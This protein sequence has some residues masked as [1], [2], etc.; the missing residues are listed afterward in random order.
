MSHLCRFNTKQVL[1][2]FYCAKIC[3]INFW[4]LHF[5]YLISCWYS[6]LQSIIIQLIL[7][8]LCLI[9]FIL[10][11][12]N[13]TDIIFFKICKFA[14]LLLSQEMESFVCECDSE[15]D[16]LIIKWKLIVPRLFFSS[17]FYIGILKVLNHLLKINVPKICH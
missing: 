8:F 5:R 11:L 2:S 17:F 3:S 16:K 7:P 9:S 10:S 4:Y 13:Q 6:Y 15:Y 14:P 1:Y 12:I